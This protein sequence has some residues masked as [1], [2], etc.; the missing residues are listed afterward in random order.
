MKPDPNR[1]L[2]H[3][4]TLVNSPIITH[5]ASISAVLDYSSHLTPLTSKL[6]L[7]NQEEMSRTFM[8]LGVAALIPAF[9]PVGVKY[10][11]NTIKGCNLSMRQ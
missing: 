4:L 11:I 7:P 9:M 1:G 3:V 2:N 8:W 6:W 5:P 10:P